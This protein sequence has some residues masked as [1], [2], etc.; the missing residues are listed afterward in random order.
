MNRLNDTA[1]VTDVQVAADLLIEATGDEEQ[2][3]EALE[4][5]AAAVLDRFGEMA[6]STAK[7]R[8]FS[9]ELPF[10]AQRFSAAWLI[11]VLSQNRGALNFGDTERLTA[12]LCDRAIPE[13]YPVEVNERD[14]TFEKLQALERFANSL[15]NEAR[16]LIERSVHLDRIEQYREDL[17]RFL[18][19]SRMR[20]I[21]E[22]L[23]PATLAYNETQHLL[24]T[25]VEYAESRN[26]P[27]ANVYDAACEA[28]LDYRN[29]ATNFGST[30]SQE[31]LVGLATNLLDTITQEEEK[32]RPHL[33]YSAMEK[34]Y[35][36]K[37]VG[38]KVTFYVTVE[39]TGTGPARDL[40]LTTL[41]SLPPLDDI[42][43]PTPITTFQAGDTAELVVTGTVREPS[44]EVR[45]ELRLSWRRNNGQ[46]ERN[47]DG[48]TFRAQRD[49]VDW[50]LVRNERPYDHTAP[51]TSTEHLYGRRDEL[52][53]LATAANAPT[54]GSSYLFGQKRVGKTSLANALAEQLN[55][56]GQANGI[57]WVVIYGGSGD[58]VM[59]DAVSTFTQLGTFL[60]DQIR[61]K[62]ARRIPNIM[63]YPVPDFTKGL[64]PLSIFIDHV[65]DTDEDD[66][67]RMLFILDEFDE[68]PTEFLRR[69]ELARALFQPIRQISDKPKCGFLLVGGENIGQLMVLQGDRLNK[70]E[71]VG[72][73]YLNRPE[74]ADLIREP[75]KHWLTITNEALEALF[76]YCSGNPFYAKLLAA[77]LRDN[78]AAREDSNASRKDVEGA[79]GRKTREIPPNSF[80]HFWMDGILPNSDEIER[81]QTARRFVL[82]A[83]SQL[84]NDD[85]S[86]SRTGVVERAKQSRDRTL[87][88]SDY[89]AA[90][91]DLHSRKIIVGYGDEI[92]MKM[93]LFKNWLMQT[94]G[95]SILPDSTQRLYVN[96]RQEEEDRYKVTDDEVFTLCSKFDS[97]GRRVEPTSVREWLSSFGATR[98]QRLMFDLLQGVTVYGRDLE[99]EKLREAFG[100]VTRDMP[101]S[102]S[103]GRYPN[104]RGILV[105]C[106]DESPARGGV[107]M[108]R[109]FAGE[110]G[111]HADSFVYAGDLINAINRR[112]RVQRLVL[113]DDFSG[114]GG[115]LL[116]ALTSNLQT[117]KRANSKGIRIIVIA[118]AGFTMAQSRI[119]EFIHSNDLDA[120]VHFCDTLGEEYMA[121]SVRSRV[122]PNPSD[123]DRA[124][125]VAEQKGVALYSEHPLGYRGCQAL[126]VFDDHCPNNSL[127][128]LWSDKNGWPALFPR[129]GI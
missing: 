41:N 68:L 59:S 80:A 27:T 127:P 11:W 25:V 98:D 83:A 105:S 84:L 67:I 103:V 74:F 44:D 45:L 64:A 110:N 58:Y 10:A 86:L 4:L 116:T 63:K 12:S 1:S 42:S 32:S 21:L 113:I 60:F 55:V 82:T 65:L 101:S 125:D 90:L 56:D 54:V 117:L 76:E 15:M 70:F 115:T 109:L 3:T 79:I 119:N 97:A 99:R 124:K 121:F 73:D 13:A 31:I 62:L 49:D 38:S 26:I 52:N 5:F 24:H 14:Q 95:D 48:F 89:Y 87:L 88:E 129:R 17:L 94:G 128:I 102:D 50:A 85:E 43:D 96:R 18:N 51:V 53:K 29:K 91:D 111:L 2:A 69:T 66:S 78:M 77:E 8:L 46:N 114:T 100:I 106:L 34:R 93:P 75:V 33:R 9:P 57:D 37:E 72:I 107:A 71:A 40:K 120:V 35:P 104:H 19:R 39:N 126:I 122:F 36:F 28:C 112:Q 108:C 22:Q 123:R 23:L 47:D 30:V 20:P 6:S 92:D 16:Q 81:I 118:I 61:R 7:N